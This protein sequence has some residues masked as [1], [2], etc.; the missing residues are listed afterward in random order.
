MAAEI[1]V[2]DT[3]TRFLVTL[4]DGTTPVDLSTATTKTFKF[5]PPGGAATLSKTATFVTDGTDGQ[6]YYDTLNTDLSV[7]GAWKLQVY[8]AMPS[9]TGHSDIG[10]FTVYE[11][12]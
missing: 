7:I 4:L 2:S 6:L 9:W 8:I 11:N 1:H 5:K 10:T 12:L 3:K